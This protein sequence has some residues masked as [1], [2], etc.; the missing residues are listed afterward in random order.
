MKRMY[1]QLV[2]EVDVNSIVNKLKKYGI[3]IIPSY[4]VADELKQLKEEYNKSFEYSGSGF[5][6]KHIHPTNKDGMV[7]RVKRK[8]LDLNDFPTLGKIFSSNFM[9]KVLAEYFSPYQYRLNND[10][11]ITH[12]KPF[13]VPILPWHYDRQQALKF[14]IYV[15]DTQQSDGAFEYVP[16]SH[17][18]GRYRANYHLAIGTPLQQLPNDIPEDEILNP[19]TIEGKAGDLIIFDTDG[20][21][22]G[23][24]VCEGGERM[25][26]R[27]H[28]HPYPVS[29]GYGQARLF[30]KNWFLQSNF[31]FAKL[32]NKHYSR[33]SGNVMQSKAAKNRD[34]NQKNLLDI[35]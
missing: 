12:E 32:F 22:R 35:K 10:I 17:Y 20:F 19:V 9:E 29:V 30:S 16:G 24:I 8:E 28:S 26:V 2:S 31:N 14:Y 18:E 25:V 15:K 13:D 27:G 4:I 5:C 6:V 21:H 34:D 23:G 7:V 3:A 11:F 1:Q 33:I